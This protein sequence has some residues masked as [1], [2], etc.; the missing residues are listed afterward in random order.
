M[1]VKTLHG[2]E[3]SFEALLEK[4]DRTAMPRH[5][6]IIMDGNRR[7]A[8]S[9]S[10]PPL[11]G[12]RAGAKVFKTIVETFVKLG[13]GVLTAYA[14]SCENW[15][16]SEDE[17]GVLLSLFEYYSRK[18]RNHLQKNGVRFR[19]IGNIDELPPS[20]SDEFSK[21]EELTRGNDRLVLNLAVNYGSR[22]EIMKA[23]LALSRDLSLGAVRASE[24]T[25]ELFSRYLL[26]AGLPDP[27]LL[28]RTSGEMR[29]SNFLL[30]QIAYSE[31]WFTSSYWPEFTPRELLT[32]ILDYQK[33]ERRFGGSTVQAHPCKTSSSRL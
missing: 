6:A 13:I 22:S 24:V 32:A 2:R 15:K 20:L 30:W 17:V 31:L 7:W 4:L 26:T 29:V 10:L 21:T 1:A 9:R 3:L 16:R 25:E 28:I 8:K 11:M 12:H 14:F 27:D 5:I 33:R 23:A 19:I 18:E